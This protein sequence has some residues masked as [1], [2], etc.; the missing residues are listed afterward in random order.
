MEYLKDL[1]RE[2][3]FL[4]YVVPEIPTITANG[5]GMIKMAQ[6]SEEQIIN[7]QAN[8]IK[9]QKSAEDYFLNIAKM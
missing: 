9:F 7:F 3:G 4:V 6:L 2:D 1:L 5:G 8:L